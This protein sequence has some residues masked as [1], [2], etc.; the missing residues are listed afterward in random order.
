MCEEVYVS[1]QL[2]LVEMMF[3]FSRPYDDPPQAAVTRDQAISVAEAAANA[4]LGG[5][6][7]SFQVHATNLVGN[8][9]QRKR[10]DAGR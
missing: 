1:A 5:Q 10:R 4:D 8:E 2:G 6:D 3:D 9:H 7:V